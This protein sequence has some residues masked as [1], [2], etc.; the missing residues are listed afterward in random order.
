MGELT[1]I[2][3]KQKEWE[4]TILKQSLEAFVN[5]PGNT[6]DLSPTESMAAWHHWHHNNVEEI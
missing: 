1:E 3:K 4:D 5:S 2:E 6:Y